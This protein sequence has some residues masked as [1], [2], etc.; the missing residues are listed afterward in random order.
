M[1]K[2]EVLFLAIGGLEG[3]RL[4]ATEM[5]EQAPNRALAH[6]TVYSSPPRTRPSHLCIASK[7]PC[8]MPVI[9][10]SDPTS[11]NSGSTA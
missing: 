3:A 10:A 4:E 1:K 7:A 9:P 6:T 2:S 8:A 5:P 11:M